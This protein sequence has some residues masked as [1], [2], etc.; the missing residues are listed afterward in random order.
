MANSPFS[1][2]EPKEQDKQIKIIRFHGG[3]SGIRKAE[4]K[5]TRLVNRGWKIITSGGGVEIGS[6]FVILQKD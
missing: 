5:L 2:L 3:Q 1:L 6:G 4:E